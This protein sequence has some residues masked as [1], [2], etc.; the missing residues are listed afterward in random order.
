MKQLPFSSVLLLPVV[1]TTPTVC[2]LLRL[3]PQQKL[4]SAS[5]NECRRSTTHHLLGNLTAVSRRPTCNATSFTYCCWT[6]RIKFRRCITVYKCEHG[7]APGYLSLS[8]VCRTVSALQGDTTDILL[9]AAKIFL[10][11]DVPLIGKRSFVYA[12][13]SVWNSLPDDIR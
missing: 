8:V 2:W 5:G 13:S 3:S 12:T 9:V 10:V 7:M 11:S 1:S 6:Y 4:Q